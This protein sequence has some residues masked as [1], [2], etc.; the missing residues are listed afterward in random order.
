MTLKE[1]ESVV[2]SLANSQDY[3]RTYVFTDEDAA[4]EWTDAYL[5][6]RTS[7]ADP[8]FV[9]YGGTNINS[10]L[11]DNWIEAKVEHFIPVDRNVIAVVLDFE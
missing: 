4:D 3:H 11:Q 9:I 8:I 7:E 10:Y 6:K 2:V 5:S 1:L